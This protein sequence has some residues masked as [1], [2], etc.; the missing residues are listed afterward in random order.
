MSRQHATP[1]IVP[2]EGDAVALS[3][4]NADA[5]G[6]SEAEVQALVQAHPDCLPIREIDP[7]F[8]DPVPL[9]REMNTGAGLIDNVL[10]TAT[11]LPVLVECK[12]WRNPQA[13]REVVG[14]ILDYATQ[15]SRWT[16]SDLQR[17]VSQRTKRTPVEIVSHVHPDLDEIAFT[18]ALT[19]NLRRGRFLLLIV[20]DGIREGVEAIAEYL[21]G[22]AGLH[23]TL[24]LVEMPI[25]AMPDGARLVAP[26]VLARTVNVT[27]E[28]VA[29]PDGMLLQEQGGT[30]EP[31]ADHD[32]LTLEETARIGF[33]GSVLTGLKLDDPEQL[34]KPLPPKGWVS[35]YLPAPSASCY[36]SLLFKR[37]KQQIGLRLTSDAGTVGEQAI[38]SVLT[39]W[40]QIKN[41]LGGSAVLEKMSQGRFRITEL[42]KLSKKPPEAERA[43]SV[44]WMQQRINDYVNVFRP[45]IKAAV[46]AIMDS[47]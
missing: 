22:Q 47:N 42:K 32:P 15:L 24:G 10:I 40:N 4:L 21:Q 6:W 18:D 44:L 19:L 39:D 38:A 29:V 20:G 1:L 30:R 27:R 36:I 11:G 25:Y 35:I 12:L 23:F 45:R 26:R 31:D 16:A 9:C 34:I 43:A 17:E 37:S 41:E 5:H 28:V 8:A 3:P 2:A 13:R 14:Q 46:A 7:L 33:M